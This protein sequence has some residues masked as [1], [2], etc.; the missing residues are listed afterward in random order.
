[1]RKMLQQRLWTSTNEA[2]WQD[3]KVCSF[4]KYDELSEAGFRSIRY[5]DRDKYQTRW[6]PVKRLP[7]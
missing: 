5:L 7:K 6:V 2:D 1:M 3:Y 4:N